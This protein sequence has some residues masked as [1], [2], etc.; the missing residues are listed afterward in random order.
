M[1]NANISIKGKIT[2]IEESR[3]R[4]S[5]VNIRFVDDDGIAYP[6]E[7]I[8][9]DTGPIIPEYVHPDEAGEYEIPDVDVEYTSD[10]IVETA[11]PNILYACFVTQ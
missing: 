1:L 5:Q 9:P 8:D 7:R 3:V 10:T 11:F 6:A 2:N 4:P